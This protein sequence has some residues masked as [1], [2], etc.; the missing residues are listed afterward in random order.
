MIDDGC[1][2]E[3]PVGIKLVEV[4]VGTLGIEED[5]VYCRSK[6]VPRTMANMIEFFHV[7]NKLS[8][9]KKVYI[10]AET[11]EMQPYT[12]RVKEYFN[13]EMIKICKGM[14]TVTCKPLGKILPAAV[15]LSR[16]PPFPVRMFENSEDACEWIKELKNKE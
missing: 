13:A 6:N 8:D 2:L 5:V 9:G 4:E 16:K 12:P 7:L 10:V 1:R 15:L 11:T 3:I 14:A